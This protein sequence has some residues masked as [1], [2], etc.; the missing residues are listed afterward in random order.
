MQVE[1][2][3]IDPAL[4]ETARRNLEH[5]IAREASTPRSQRGRLYLA[6]SNVVLWLI[7]HD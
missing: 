3:L 6:P 2:I 1:Q 4:S 5:V 7:R